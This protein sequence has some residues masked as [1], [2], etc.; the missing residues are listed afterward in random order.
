MSS[1]AKESK[2]TERKVVSRG[3]IVRLKKDVTDVEETVRGVQRRFA[4]VKPEKVLKRSVKGFTIKGNIPEDVLQRLLGDDVI[5]SIEPDIQ[6]KMCAQGTGWAIQRLGCE[7]IGTGAAIDADIF[8]LDTGVK[9]HPDLNIASQESFIDYEPEVDAMNP[10][11]NSCAGCAAAI[12]NDGHLV[13]TCPGARIHGYKVL[14]AEGSGYLSCIIAGIDRVLDLKYETPALK[15]VINL[16][17]GGYAGSTAYTAL[18]WAVYS[19]IQDYGVPVVVAAGN[20]SSNASL[21]TP[22]HV[23]EC[24]TV[25]AYGIGSKWA[26]FSNF[27]GIV[28]ILAPGVN[29][30]TTGLNSDL[31]TMSGTSFA[32]PMCSGLVALHLSKNP[33]LTPAQIFTKIKTIATNTFSGKNPKILSVPVGT[34]AYSA[35][36]VGL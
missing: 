27:G 3:Y 35:Y 30:T 8:I 31:V 1:S 15:A 24:L 9:A 33:T 22:A 32:A 18:D 2:S 16:S 36:A 4:S 25:G 6:V 26:P 17:L 34:P 11:G 29:I 14:D 13:G 28:D 10:H 7:N 23:R 5:E 20:E 12:D 21:C 19:A